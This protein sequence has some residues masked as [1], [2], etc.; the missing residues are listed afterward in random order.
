[1]SDIFI[2]ESITF[3]PL[4]L[5]NEN[6]YSEDS[7]IVKISMGRKFLVDIWHPF[8]Y[9]TRQFPDR[10][11]S[12]C[13]SFI[14]LLCLCPHGLC[15]HTLFPMH[16]MSRCLRQAQLLSFPICMW[17]LSACLSRVASFCV[18]PSTCLISL[19][20]TEVRLTEMSDTMD[21]LA[22]RDFFFFF[23]RVYRFPI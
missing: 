11:S 3:Y 20:G 6:A 15:S 14:R 5:S 4:C 19:I 17:F 1:M 18:F 10:L 9:D 8:I 23:Y 22:Q 2:I 12:L 7:E 13:W 21:Q 16:C